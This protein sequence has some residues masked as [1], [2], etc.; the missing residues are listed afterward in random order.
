VSEKVFGDRIGK[1][2]NTK[3]VVDCEATVGMTNHNLK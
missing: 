1:H 3:K 2:A